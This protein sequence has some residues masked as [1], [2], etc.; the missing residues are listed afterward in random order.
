MD[1]EK[2]YKRI[3]TKIKENAWEFTDDVEK[4]RV[5]PV[6]RFIAKR[7]GKHLKENI[8]VHHHMQTRYEP[9]PASEQRLGWLYRGT[10]V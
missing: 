7:N 2:E 3:I 10:G 1:G 5:P 4:A 8:S 6:L 9:I